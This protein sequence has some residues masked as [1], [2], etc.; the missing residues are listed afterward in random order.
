MALDHTTIAVSL[1]ILA[2]IIIY[3]VWTLTKRGYNTTISW[4]LYVMAIRFPIVPFAIG[5][6]AGHLFWPNRAGQ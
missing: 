2:V 1:V 3:D 5:V 6:V 4:N